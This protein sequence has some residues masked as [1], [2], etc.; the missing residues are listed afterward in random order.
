MLPRDPSAIGSLRRPSCMEPYVL[1]AHRDGSIGINDA[2]AADARN[3][4]RRL[5]AFVKPVRLRPALRS[6]VLGRDPSLELER[7]RRR[8]LE[9][10]HRAA[11]VTRAAPT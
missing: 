8:C 7:L 1:E 9:M 11:F 2:F 4:P 10:A 5:G 3:R 6:R